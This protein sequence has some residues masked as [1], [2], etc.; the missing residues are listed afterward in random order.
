MNGDDGEESDGDLP[1][2]TIDAGRIVVF[3]DEGGRTADSVL[4][5]DGE[6]IRVQGM[7]QSGEGDRW[8]HIEDV[9]AV[10]VQR[11]EAQLVLP[12]E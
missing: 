9:V 7:T 1:P 10:G 3:F 5:T 11:D 12:D 4:E 8:L 6:F 2:V